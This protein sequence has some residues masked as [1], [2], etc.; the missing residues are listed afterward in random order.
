MIILIIKIL[1]VIVSILSLGI[2]PL[3][4]LL[5]QWIWNTII[6][7]DVLPVALPIHSFWIALGLT[8]IGSF[9]ISHFIIKLFK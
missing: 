2:L 8:T 5:N 4:A 7:T 1:L 6:V 9:S 3:L